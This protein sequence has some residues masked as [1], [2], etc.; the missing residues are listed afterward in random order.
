[1]GSLG[2][3]C[4]TEKY[5]NYDGTSPLAPRSESQM[6]SGAMWQLKAQIINFGHLGI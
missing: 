2:L 4:M 5:V 6:F 3:G 1:M